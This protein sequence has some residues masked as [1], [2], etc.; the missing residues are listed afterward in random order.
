MKRIGI[1]GGSFDP[2]HRAHLEIATRATEQIPLDT[3]YFVPSY[4][5][6][7]KG[8]PAVASAHHRMAMIQLL[9]GL[10]TEWQVLSYEIDQR[11]AV[12]TIETTEDLKQHHPQASCYLIMGG[13]QAAQ[14]TIWRD[15]QRLAGLVHIVCFTRAGAPPVEPFTADLTIIPYYAQLA[16]TMVRD[17]IRKGESTDD[18]LTPVVQA[19]IKKHQ[20]YQ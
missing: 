18:S 14:F 7:L 20:L 4:R 9:A 1:F 12:A 19:Y 3:L 17:R 16:S 13:D 11:R 5:S 10:R 15:W 2:P 6:P 8:Q